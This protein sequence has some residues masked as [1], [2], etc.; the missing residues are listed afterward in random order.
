MSLVGRSQLMSHLELTGLLTMLND[1]WWGD[2]I[3]DRQNY[4]LAVL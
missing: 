2:F 3:L 1:S 4:R